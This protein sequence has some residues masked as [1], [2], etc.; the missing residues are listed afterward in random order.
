MQD[1]KVIK[2]DNVKS[3]KIIAS[4]LL[5]KKVLLYRYFIKQTSS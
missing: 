1:R 3:W 2:I 4:K 5:L